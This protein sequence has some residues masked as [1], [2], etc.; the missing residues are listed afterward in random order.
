MLDKG[1]G[2]IFW[3]ISWQQLFSGCVGVLHNLVVQRY[4]L[5]NERPMAIL[6]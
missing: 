2:F 4:A 1:G 3:H 5:G 6:I